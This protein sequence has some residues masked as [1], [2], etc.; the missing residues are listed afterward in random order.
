M[1]T[2]STEFSMNKVLGSLSEVKSPGSPQQRFHHLNTIHVLELAMYFGDSQTLVP[3][4][5]SAVRGNCIPSTQGFQALSA[6]KREF[7]YHHSHPHMLL[8]DA[9]LLQLSQEHCIIINI[10]E[11]WV[12]EHGITYLVR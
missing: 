11:L 4:V 6:L 9:I 8:P 2:R 3:G 1:C 12:L 5:L 10:K 7:R